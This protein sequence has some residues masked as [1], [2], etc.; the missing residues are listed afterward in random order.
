MFISSRLEQ[1]QV[2]VLTLFLLLI[3]HDDAVISRWG[4]NYLQWL[5]TVCSVCFVLVML[6]CGMN[7]KH[8]TLSNL[9][10][11]LILHV[12]LAVVWSSLLVFHCLV[13]LLWLSGREPLSSLQCL[14]L[15]CDGFAFSQQNCKNLSSSLLSSPLLSSLLFFSPLLKLDAKASLWSSRQNQTVHEVTHSAIRADRA[16]VAAHTHHLQVRTSEVSRHSDQWV[17]HRLLWGANMPVLIFS[18]FLCLSSPPL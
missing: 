7:E 9:I 15:S 11:V 17:Q 6:W 5:P 8:E 16:E 3:L 10:E 12:L 13:L 2:K 1:P 18:A 4:E 14:V